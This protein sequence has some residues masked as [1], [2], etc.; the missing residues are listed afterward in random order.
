MSQ[1]EGADCGAQ[2]GERYR[3]LAVPLSGSVAPV[4]E[5]GLDQWS[6]GWS[7]QGEEEGVD[8]AG[9]EQEFEP[10]FPGPKTRA[11]QGQ[12]GLAG[13]VAHLH[14]PASGVSQ[15]HP[16]G[17]VNGSHGPLVSRYQGLRPLPGRDTTSHS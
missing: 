2:S 1:P 14:L 17:I 11:F 8:Q 7:E 12:V 4:S 5:Q 10:V 3:G 15:D 6:Q 16:P 13:S 9:H